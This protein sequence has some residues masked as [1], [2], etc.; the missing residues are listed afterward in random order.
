MTCVRACTWC[1]GGGLEEGVLWCNAA[2]TASRC[3]GL[4]HTHTD[5]HRHTQTHTHT[6]S[7]QIT[8]VK[9][10]THARTRTY[11]F[12]LTP[13]YELL[14]GLQ[15]LLRADLPDDYEQVVSCSCCSSRSPPPPCPRSPVTESLLGPGRRRAAAL[16]LPQ[17]RQCRAHRDLHDNC[18]CAR[19][20]AS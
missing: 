2:A 13:L 16:V 17:H 4:T 11:T 12:A 1:G 6:L 3:G 8:C 20:A 19:G 7:Q 10:A 5:I 18:R 14:G 15:L 9:T